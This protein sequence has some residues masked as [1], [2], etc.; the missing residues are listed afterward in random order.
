MALLPDRY[1]ISFLVCSLK[2]EE[3]VGS[4][5]MTDEIEAQMFCEK[6]YLLECK[7]W[8]WSL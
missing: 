6:I 3:W 8:I 7:D 5:Q 2:N 1:C 4:K